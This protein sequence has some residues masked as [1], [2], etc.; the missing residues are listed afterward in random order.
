MDHATP[1]SPDG[2]DREMLVAVLLVREAEEGRK[3]LVDLATARSLLSDAHPIFT[4]FCAET[5]H[6]L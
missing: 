2:T 1:D 6:C 4:P 3:V 5:A